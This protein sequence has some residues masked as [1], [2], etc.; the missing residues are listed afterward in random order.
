MNDAVFRLGLSMVLLA[1]VT[2]RS[3]PLIG[4]GVVAAIG[5]Q[6]TM[7]FLPLLA[8]V[9]FRSR[10]TAGVVTAAVV[11]AVYVVTGRIAEPF[12][13][14]SING[15]TLTGLFADLR[16]GVGVSVFAR[17]AMECASAVVLPFALLLFVDLR[18]A[19]VDL[20]LQIALALL[21]A[22]IIAS[23]LL[24]GPSIMGGNAA[25]LTALASAPLLV[26]AGVLLQRAGRPAAEAPLFV[27]AVSAAAFLGSLHHIYS[28]GPG[29]TEF[30]LLTLAA[31]LVLVIAA[32]VPMLKRHPAPA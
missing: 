16:A 11:V 17:F 32:S 3:S 20:R 2:R 4:G 7:T 10:R 13:E 18:R 21:W 29:R 9:S 12:S 22:G 15:S 31:L 14:P 24:G 23:P 27:V 1:L 5:R 19:A 28:F 26:H 6:T 30:G 8:F 25:R